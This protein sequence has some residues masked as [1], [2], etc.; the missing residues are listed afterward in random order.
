[1][2]TNLIAGS[3]SLGE[4]RKSAASQDGLPPLLLAPDDVHIRC[5]LLMLC[6]DLGSPLSVGKYLLVV[7][8]SCLLICLFLFLDFFQVL[9]NF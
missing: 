3:V 4:F 1:M 7:N 9:V 8:C 6:L 5:W 2:I